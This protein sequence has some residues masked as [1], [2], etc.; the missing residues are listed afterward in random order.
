MSRFLAGLAV[1]AVGVLF[2]LI[3]RSGYRTGEAFSTWPYP[4]IRR[5]THAFLYPFLQWSYVAMAILLFIAGTLC[6]VG[7]TPN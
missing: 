5:D 1:L 4:P 6:L 2:G 3:A 7:L